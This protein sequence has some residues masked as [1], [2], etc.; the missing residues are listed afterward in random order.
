MGNKPITREEMLLNAVSTGEAANLEP[1]TREEMFL[2]KLGGADVTPPMPITRKEQFLQKAIEGGGSGGGSFGEGENKV[3][4]DILGKREANYSS[5]REFVIASKAFAN[6]Q[7]A[8]NVYFPNAVVA[9]SEVFDNAVKL[10]TVKIK[11]VQGSHMYV[12]RYCYALTSCEVGSYTSI[13]TQMFMYC[14]S[15]ERLKIKGTDQFW[16]SG[17]QFFTNCKKL[18]TLIL[19]IPK[20]VNMG[21][22]PLAST[23]IAAS[24]TAT[25]IE[26]GTGYIYV[27]KA[28][29]EDYKVATNWAIYADR[30]RAIEDY[31]DICGEVTA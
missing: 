3:L 5:E 10:K 19:D 28:Y 15:L 21:V 1:I 8:E 29:I 30:F 17:I 26:Y 9:G 27:R 18:K 16:V 23:P 22:D 20:M 13:S 25:D 14:T 6:N 11:E 7:V 24:G 12:F 2:A 31:P 4:L